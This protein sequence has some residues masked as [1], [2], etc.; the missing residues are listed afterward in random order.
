[1]KTVTRGRPFLCR[2]VES[3]AAKNESQC[4]SRRGHVVVVADA[5]DVCED[6]LWKPHAPQ[7]VIPSS[8][9]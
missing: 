6:R 5:G 3:G 2:A 1:M 7:S 4:R 9:Q 8:Q